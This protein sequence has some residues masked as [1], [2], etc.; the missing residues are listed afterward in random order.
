MRLLPVATLLLLLGPLCKGQQNRAHKSDAQA[1]TVAA[2][3]AAYLIDPRQPIQ[4]AIQSKEDEQ[5]EA[6][7]QNFKSGRELLLDKGVTFEPEELLREHR[8]K[9]L[10]DALDAMPE[11]HQSRYET[12]PV[13]GAYLADTLY[14]PEKVQLSGHTIIVAN[15]VVFEGKNPVIRGHYDLHF[16]PAK[17][18]AVLGTTLAQ[19]LH[20]KNALV[21]VRLGGMPVL[22]SFSLIQD[23]RD[24]G[25]HHITFDTSGPEP[26][27][28][29]PPPRKA[30]PWLTGVSW[31]GWPD[32][33]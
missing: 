29:R 19:A 5:F 10:Q 9:A 22:P 24:R 4:A 3:D 31:S 27:S 8:S 12:A 33:I 13:R 18:V 16:F 17:P 7:R 25:P 21:N 23:L 1:Q 15:Y 20:K 26:Q 11:M 32:A 14:L 6:R 30:P 28:L 2:V